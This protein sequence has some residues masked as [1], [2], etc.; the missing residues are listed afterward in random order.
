MGEQGLV[1]GHRTTAVLTGVLAIPF[2]GREDK[3]LQH[4]SSFEHNSALNIKLCQ[5]LTEVSYTCKN[6]VKVLVKT[7]P[8]KKRRGVRE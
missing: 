5:F 4:L 1:W 7:S 2:M 3:L 8:Y 6:L